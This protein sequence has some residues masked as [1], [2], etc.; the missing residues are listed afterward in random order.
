MIPI[1]I[2]DDN[3]IILERYKNKLSSFAKDYDYPVSFSCFL[4]GEQLL[5]HLEEEPNKAAVIILDV[6]M[7]GINGI[8]TAKK[9]RSMGCH[10]EII[11]LTST[12]DF[13]FESFDSSPLH[14]LLKGAANEDEK[15]KDVFIK[16]IQISLRKETEMFFCEHGAHKKKIPLY[17]ISYFEVY[18]RVVI[19]HYLEGSFEFYSSIDAVEA[20][21]KDK[22]FIR[23]HRSF[24]V[25][26]PYINDIQKTEILLTT[27]DKIPLGT[28]YAKK[29]K[30]AFSAN[31]SDI[32]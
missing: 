23:C 22:K 5:F 16:A 4:S 29:V 3:P 8:E 2:C 30:L 31:L 18:G 32:D 10:S 19:V 28:T 11:F 20:E 25:N 24:L 9:L 26:L 1:V 14:Y 7:G 27:G 17:S 12:E 15:L 21:L 13:V 6:L